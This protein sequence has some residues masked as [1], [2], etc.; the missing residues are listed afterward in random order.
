MTSTLTV[1]MRGK[2]E[3]VLNE[4]LK[5]GYAATKSEALRYALLHLGEEMGL[6]QKRIHARSEEYAYQEYKRR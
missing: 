2:P 1:Q 6:L 4:L 3:E 5:K